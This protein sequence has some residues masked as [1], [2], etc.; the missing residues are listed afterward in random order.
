MLKMFKQ[1][2]QELKKGRPGQRFQER[3][4]RA[5]AAR[6]TGGHSKRIVRII[7]ALVSLGI[8]VVL[9]VIPGPAILFFFVGGGLL[10]TESLWIARLMDWIEVKARALWAWG[11]KRW[12][13][14][15]VPGKIAVIFVGA[16][17]AAGAAYFIYRFFLR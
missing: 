8:G 6:K 17:G 15:S 7:L 9:V 14:L 1:H 4:Q 11:T 13:G 16:L 5:K 10:A 2:M 3:Y 12:R